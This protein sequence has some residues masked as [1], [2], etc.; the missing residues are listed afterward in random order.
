MLSSLA[1]D[2][3]PVSNS[4]SATRKASA[5]GLTHTQ[6]RPCSFGMP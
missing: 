4:T 3:A 2:P 5:T 1:K 6:K